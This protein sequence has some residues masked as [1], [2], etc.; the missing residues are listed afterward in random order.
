MDTSEDNPKPTG[1]VCK[2][3]SVFV[4]AGNGFDAL[5]MGSGAASPDEDTWEILLLKSCQYSFEQATM[6]PALFLS[7]ER[8]LKYLF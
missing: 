1:L 6:V 7:S 5:T 3:L 4:W 8:P 2:K